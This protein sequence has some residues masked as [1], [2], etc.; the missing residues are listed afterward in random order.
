MSRYLPRSSAAEDRPEELG[1]RADRPLERE[2]D[3][4]L[5]VYIN[6]EA[7]THTRIWNDS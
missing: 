5:R 3:C 4:I 6:D 1:L 2:V 7:N